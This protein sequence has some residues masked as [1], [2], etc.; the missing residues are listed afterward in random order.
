MSQST[1]KMVDRNVQVEGM[2]KVSGGRKEGKL[3]NFQPSLQCILGNK[4]TWV[5]ETMQSRHGS[6]WRK[7]T[8][9]IKLQITKVPTGGKVSGF[10]RDIARLRGCC[11]DFVAVT[12]P[13]AW[14]GGSDPW[15][16]WCVPAA[17]RSSVGEA[18]PS[19]DDGRE[20]S[21]LQLCGR[22]GSTSTDRSFVGLWP[23]RC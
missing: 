7:I 17:L 20:L 6:A 16:L 21:D 1:L 23:Q 14:V 15:L 2:L 8:K 12:G 4:L 5:R 19:P 22:A 10:I 13:P 9:K 11:A 18:N 3:Q